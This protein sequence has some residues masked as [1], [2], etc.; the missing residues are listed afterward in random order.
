MASAA[1]ASNAWRPG[2]VGSLAAAR[3]AP[4]SVA[5]QTQADVEFVLRHCHVGAAAH[6]LDVPCGSGRHTLEL[7]RHG[8]EVTGIDLSAEAIDDARASA[9]SEGLAAHFML[10]D[11]R[12]LPVLK[13]FDGVVCL[14]NSA[15]YFGAKDTQIFFNMIAAALRP[16]GWL[17]LDSYTCAESVFPLEKER[18]LDIDGM[19]Y[20][21]ALSYD[22][23]TSI[24]RTAGLLTVDG[25]E[26]A[27]TQAH[28]V[29]TA[30]ELVRSLAAA[31][32]RVTGLYADPDGTP[33]TPGAR[34]LLLHAVRAY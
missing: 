1:V 17:V 22:P 12:E 31:G 14:G 34:R 10:A 16:H 18:D 13:P 30:G 5:R 11:M 3:M 25:E 4:A 15:S 20:R 8:H 32:L 7:A 21:A 29:M 23:R 2:M 33:F 19:S 28:R 27:V 26:R 6:L 9:M 24:L